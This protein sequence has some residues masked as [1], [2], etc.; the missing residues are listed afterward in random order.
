MSLK[1]LM[2]SLLI[3]EYETIYYLKNPNEND[4]DETFFDDD[5]NFI[6][7]LDYFYKNF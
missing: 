1:Y 4:F 3:S 5:G 6:D 7:D 2:I